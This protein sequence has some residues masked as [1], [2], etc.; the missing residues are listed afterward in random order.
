MMWFSNKKTE[1]IP[2]LKI[3]IT[4]IKSTGNTEIE[5]TDNHNIL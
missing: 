5:Y 1:P 4:D 3:E 2:K